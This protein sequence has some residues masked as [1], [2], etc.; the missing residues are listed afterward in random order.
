MFEVNAKLKSEGPAGV[1]PS[2]EDM[3]AVNAQARGPL[4]PE[5]VYI[6][7]VKAADTHVDRD[8]ERFSPECIRGLAGLYTGKTFLLDHVWSAHSQT[9]R[10]FRAEARD[11]EDGSCSLI[12]SCYVIREGNEK[13][14]A[15]IEGGILREVSV[16][17][18][19]KKTTCSICGADF[20]QCE[21]QRGAT[22]DGVLCVAVLSEPTDAYEVSF[23]AVPAQREAGVQKNMHT[24]NMSVQDLQKAKMRLQIEK[25]RY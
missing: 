18:A 2:A 13:L 17:C 21:H 19:V 12:L 5:D 25:I 15:A 6:F 10:I 22:Y 4:E 8:F 3:E 16:G 23:V 1:T 9:A 14:I 11:E 20:S 7:R 24:V